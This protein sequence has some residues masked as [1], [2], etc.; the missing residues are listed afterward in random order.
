M[1]S[2]RLYLR[3]LGYVRPYWRMFA[4]S[5]LG[6]LIVA[7]TEVALPAAA[8]PF[9]D[10]TFLQKDPFLMRWA[11]WGIVLLF[12][13][14]GLGSFLGQYGSN[15]VSLRVIM[16]LRQQMFA[17]LLALPLGY[18]A[19]NLSGKLISKFTF[20][21][22]QIAI[23]VTY[24]VTVLIRDS[25]TIIALLAYLLWLNWSLTLITFVM[26]PPIALAVRAFNRRLRG[27]TRQTQQAM[28]EVNHVLQESLENQKVVK[29][30][31][32]QSYEVERFGKAVNRVR[33]LL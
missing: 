24:V 26:I 22:I 31:G 4:V 7:A 17:R 33:R 15:W 20:D 9:L 18:F 8:Q 3:L 25:L 6:M 16:D 13:V 5:I 28:G 2:T 1:S 14:R 32:G 12:A 11:P 21:V 27:L 19:D 10:G 29:V 30:F 23:A